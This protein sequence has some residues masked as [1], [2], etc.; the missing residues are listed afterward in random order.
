MPVGAIMDMTL[1]GDYCGVPVSCSL[2]YKQVEPDPAAGPSPGRRL[3]QRFFA[4]NPGPWFHIR[5][6]LSQ[7]LEWLCGVVRYG[8]INE[9][10]LLTNTIGLS[11][12]PSWP[13][14]LA[15]QVNTPS[16]DPHPD[17]DEGR[18]FWP[19]FLIEDLD[20]GGI[21]PDEHGFLNTWMSRLLQLDNDGGV[22]RY[23]LYP[24]AGYLD[25]NGGTDVITTLPY[26]LPFVKVIG[27]R[28]GDDCATFAAIGGA[29]FGAFDPDPAP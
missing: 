21:D 26:W 11:P 20:K 16:S 9:V 22:F 4:D 8:E 17:A 24:H 23:L 14:S 3:V 25:K 5:D 27:N 6:K 15:L 28:K 18:F 7:D 29:Q 2:T 1:I 12:N 19:G 13:T 10:E